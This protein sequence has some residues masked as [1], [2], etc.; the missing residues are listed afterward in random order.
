[1]GKSGQPGSIPKR[2]RLRDRG[3]NQTRQTAFLLSPSPDKGE[4]SVEEAPGGPAQA[5][6]KQDRIAHF[7]GACLRRVSARLWSV[8]GAFPQG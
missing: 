5:H 8:S 2:S 4:R 7:H 3:S 6:E 1:M